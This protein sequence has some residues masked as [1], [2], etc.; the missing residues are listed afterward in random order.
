MRPPERIVG[1]TGHWEAAAPELANFLFA[2]I[3]PGTTRL[4]H[5]TLRG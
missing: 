2:P 1:I 3:P 4:N 5:S